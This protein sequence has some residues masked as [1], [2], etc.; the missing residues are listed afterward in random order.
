[1]SNLRDA[2]EAKRAGEK[3]E[4]SCHESSPRGGALFIELRPDAHTRTGFPVAQL[5]HYTLE[6][7][8]GDD[9]DAPERLTLAFHTADVVMTGARLSKLVEAIQ[10]HELTSVSALDAR[11]A[12][13]LGK[14][15]WVAS[16]AIARFDKPGAPV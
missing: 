6:A 7:N 2:I 3:A 5:C 16:I 4:P 1:M 10:R 9:K 11:Y 12:G 14:Q 8:A 13:A 15:P